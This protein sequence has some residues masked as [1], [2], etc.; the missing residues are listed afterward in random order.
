MYPRLFRPFLVVLAILAGLTLAARVDAQAVSVQ[1]SSQDAY[2]DE[3]VR[4]AVSIENVPDFEGPFI[5]DVDG[6]DIHRLPGEQTMSSTQII[7]GRTTRKSTVNIG[8]EIVPKRPGSYVV[9]A[10]TVRAGGEEYTT[11]PFRLEVKISEVGDLMRATVRCKPSPMYVGQAGVMV[12]DLAIKRYRDDR[13]GITLDEGSMWS[14]ISDDLSEW[15]IFGSALQK[16]ASENRRPRGEVQVIDGNE[17]IVYAIEKPFDPIAS[18]TPSIGDVRVRMNYPLR[19]AR[20]NDVFFENRLTLA[21]SRPVSI[22]PT[23]ESVDVRTPPDG[24]RPA[25]WNGAVGRFTLDV[26]AKP[27]DVAV[28]EP[29]TLT[30]RLTDTSG[31]AGLEGLLAPDVAAQR[32]LAESFRVPR[33]AA[34]GVVEGRSKIFT[35]SIRATTDAVREIP[36]IEFSYFDP[37]TGEYST[38]RSAAIPLQVR[39]SAIAKANVELNAEDEAREPIAASVATGTT[40][41]AGGLVANMSPADVTRAPTITARGAALAFAPPIIALGVLGGTPLL[42]SR[43][44][45]DGAGRRAKLAR[46]HCE[47]ALAAAVTADDKERALLAFVATRVG[48][49]DSGFSRGDATQALRARGTSEETIAE[50]ERVLRFLERARYGGAHTDD[51]EIRRVIDTVDRAIPTHSMSGATR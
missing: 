41:V 4:V 47:R 13:L 1:V 19:L 21:E 25:T 6:L 50:L 46:A 14:L 28:G 9:P 33:D 40:K 44:R 42:R 12:L 45:R 3:P 26:A 51:A 43:F 36:P 49:S 35:Q 2:V 27:V 31:T 18:G 32:D 34:A 39:P 37:A 30:I 38:I 15:G 22:V 20:G 48:S 29:I 16:L 24:G 10:F 17:Y 11:K 8:Y 7:N 23:V 5:G